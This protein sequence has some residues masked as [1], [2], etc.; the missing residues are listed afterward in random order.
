MNE[1]NNYGFGIAFADGQTL[2]YTG[3]S[4]DGYL[5]KDEDEAFMGYN[6]EGAL[7]KALFVIDTFV[8][9]LNREVSHVVLIN[10]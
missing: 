7:R 5:D 10:E 3:R 6:K 1:E 9:F 4:G 8:P 2:F